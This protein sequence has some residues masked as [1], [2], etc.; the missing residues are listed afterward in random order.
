MQDFVRELGRLTTF[1][2]FARAIVYLRPKESYEKYLKLLVNLIIL[3]QFLSPLRQML[4]GDTMEIAMPW[5]ESFESWERDGT[6]QVA[7]NAEESMEEQEEIRIEITEVEISPWME[8]LDVDLE[9][10]SGE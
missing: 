3:L 7:E 8:E 9:I 4:S 5:E 6:E 2:I 10:E 1:L